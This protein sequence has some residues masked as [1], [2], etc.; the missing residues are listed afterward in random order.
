MNKQELAVKGASEALASVAT[1]SGAATQQYLS[2]LLGG[3]EYAIDI[4]RVQEIKGWDTV[5]RVPYS[6]GYILGVINLRGSIVPVVDLRV[7]FSLESAAF[8]SATVIIVVH[9]AGLRGERIVGVVVDAVSDVYSVAGENIQPPPD[10]V[11]S[12]DHQFVL[13]LASLENKLVIV[14]DIERI[15]TSSVAGDNKAAA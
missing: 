8:D 4:L 11:G 7:R 10:V 14:L 15:V 12:V 3:Q 6:P 13:G 2:F 1:R 5:T 9:V